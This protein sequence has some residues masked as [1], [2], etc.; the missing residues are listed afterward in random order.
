VEL[1]ARCVIVLPD[2]NTREREYQTVFQHV[3]SHASSA[4]ECLPR[5]EGL[6]W[7]S[8]VP[9]MQ[10]EKLDG[11]NRYFCETCQNK[12]C[13]T[14]RI[15]LHSLPRTLNLQLMRFVFDRSVTEKPVH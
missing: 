3:V 10:E 2:D 8:C 4:Y 5:E 13:A 12:Q 7:G 6:M 11:D 15:K 14:R 1:N 9:G